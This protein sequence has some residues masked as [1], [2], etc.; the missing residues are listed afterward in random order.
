LRGFRIRLIAPESPPPLRAGYAW[1]PL[2]VTYCA[3]PHCN[4]AARAALKLARLGYA[5]KLMAGG[6]TGWLDEGFT[7][8]PGASSAREVAASQTG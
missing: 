1:A 4:G 2:F 8:E 3:G 7:L 5:V 6:V